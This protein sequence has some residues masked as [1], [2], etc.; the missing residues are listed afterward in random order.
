M[1][2]THWI[3]FPTFW[4]TFKSGF[5]RCT[6]LSKM[7]LLMNICLFGRADWNSE[8][9][10]QTSVRGMAW[11]CICCVKAN[12]LTFIA[13]YLYWGRKGVRRAWCYSAHAFWWL[14]FLFQ[15]CLVFDERT[16]QQG[17]LCVTLDNLYTEPYLLMALYENQTDCFGTLRKKKELPKDFWNWKPKKGIGQPDLVTRA[18]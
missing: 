1:G 2:K 4:I 5:A 6:I 8:S 15:G 3:N 11:R 7:L 9:T 17:V 14:P 16:F 10:F 12:R 13:L 18:R